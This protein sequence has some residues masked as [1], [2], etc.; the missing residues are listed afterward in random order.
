MTVVKYLLLTT[1]RQ[2]SVILKFNPTV[3]LNIFHR[4][5]AW[6]VSAFVL[7]IIMEKKLNLKKWWTQQSETLLLHMEEVMEIFVLID[8]TSFN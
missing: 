6:N 8:I 2:R 7:K 1:D 3:L 4:F 5:L